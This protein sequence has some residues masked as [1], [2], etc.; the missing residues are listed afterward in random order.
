MLSGTVGTKYPSQKCEQ[1]FMS[2]THA[3]KKRSDSASIHLQS[4]QAEL[5]KKLDKTGN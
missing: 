1:A 2:T 5:L 3:S 4:I